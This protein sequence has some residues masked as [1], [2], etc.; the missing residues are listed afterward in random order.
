MKTINDSDIKTIQLRIMDEIDKFCRKNKIDYYLS[1]GT[2]IGAVRHK[3]YIPWDDDIDIVM[4]RSDYNKFISTFSADNIEIICNSKVDDYYL[5]FAKAIDKTTLLKEHVAPNFE[6]GVYVD[7]FPMDEIPKSKIK[8]ILRR[9]KIYISLLNLKNIT[10]KRRKL[11]KNIIIIFGKIFAGFFSR[12][13]LIEKINSIST[14]HFKEKCDM[15]GNFNLLV[16]G[17]GDIWDKEDYSSTVELEFEGRK[18][19]SPVGYDSVL[20]KTFGDYM[21]LP[22]KDEQI[23]HHQFDAWWNDSN[24]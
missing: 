4:K 1:G 23:S 10:L 7:I 17:F 2:L 9:N 6:L 5:S 14:I 22:P 13:Y 12:K 15:I 16:Y 20:T 3:G 24:V 18:Y 8:Q 19:L 21:K 11:Y